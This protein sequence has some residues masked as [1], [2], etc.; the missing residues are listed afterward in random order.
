M[1]TKEP[2]TG[3]YPE[4]HEYS[5]HLP[6]L[7]LKDPFEY[8]LPISSSLFPL[9]FPCKILKIFLISH[10]DATCPV[11]NLITI[12]IFDKKHKLCS[13]LLCNFL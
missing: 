1:F 13:S 11:F 12:I 10:M 2:A 5:P 3:P 7:F 4:S 6:I 8:Y 9:G